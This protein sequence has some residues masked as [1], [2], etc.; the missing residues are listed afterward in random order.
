MSSPRPTHP[1]T[2]HPSIARTSTAERTWNGVL[3]Q[4][5]EFWC[6]GEVLHLLPF[7]DEVRLSAVLEEVGGPCEPRLHRN[8]TCPIEHTPRHMH[9]APAGMGVWG[10]TADARYVR[11]VT[12]VF[13]PRSLEERLGERFH[14][15]AMA[16][17][18]LRFSDDA[19]SSLLGFLVDAIDDAD[20]SAAL[21][22]DGLTTAIVA[23]L[24]AP[25][26][27]APR[28][29]PKLARWQLRRV[30]EYLDAHLAHP[31]ALEELAKLTGLS[32]RHFARAFKAST[33]QAP[34]RWHVERRVTRA[35]AMLV[36]THESLEEVAA[37]TGFNDASHLGRVFRRLV[38]TTPGAWRRDRRS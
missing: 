32:Q 1:D 19:L 31:I 3:V 27:S 37:A 21:Y 11:D 33:G 29:R 18:I 28:P 15:G 9:L 16:T 13:D 7:D 12:L 38:G 6:T 5:A 22:G 25:K 26:E 24:F 20:P 23:R 36:E 35:Q 4:A 2:F 17:P 8:K 34:Y 14:A 10:Y 30:V